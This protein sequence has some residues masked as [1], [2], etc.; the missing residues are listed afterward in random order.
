MNNNRVKDL[1]RV[2]NS[3]YV[4][5]LALDFI[6]YKNIVHRMSSI[7]FYFIILN[8]CTDEYLLICQ[9]SCQ[10]SPRF[11]LLQVKFL[12]F[13]VSSSSKDISSWEIFGKILY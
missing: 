2:L 4:R 10:I 7:L 9:P 5:R 13:C 11:Q 6:F 8:T 1:L 12:K 3:L